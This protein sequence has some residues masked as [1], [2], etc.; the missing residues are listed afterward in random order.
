MRIAAHVLVTLDEILRSRQR[1]GN[2]RDLL[3]E[4]DRDDVGALL[5][6]PN[7]VAAP[8]AASGTSDKGD[9]AVKLA[10]GLPPVVSADC[11]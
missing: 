1:V 7:R 8:L 2:T 10:H 6:Q 9:S 4:V 5:R 11:W 3:T